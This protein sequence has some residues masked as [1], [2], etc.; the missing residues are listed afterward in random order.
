MGKGKGGGGGEGILTINLSGL[1]SEAVFN[2]W[3]HYLKV[4]KKNT[5][6]QQ[7]R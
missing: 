4:N 1:L 5:W 6:D 3:K 2:K 7:I